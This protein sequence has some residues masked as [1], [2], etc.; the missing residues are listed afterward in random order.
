MEELEQAKADT[1]QR[2]TN[3]VNDHGPDHPNAKIPI[4]CGNQS[5]N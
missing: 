4:D 1:Y 5:K 3:A 2:Y